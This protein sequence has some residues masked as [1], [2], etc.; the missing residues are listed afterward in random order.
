[1][2]HFQFGSQKVTTI[3]GLLYFVSQAESDEEK[4]QGDIIRE[5]IQN[6]LQLRLCY[7]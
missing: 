3:L 2:P 5:K 6:R 7:W 1:M 4:A